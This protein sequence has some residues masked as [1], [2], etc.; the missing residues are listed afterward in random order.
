MTEANEADQS[1]FEII[2]DSLFTSAFAIVAIGLCTLPVTFS[3]NYLFD[4]VAHIQY[5]T[6][7]TV[8]TWGLYVAQLTI[9]ADRDTPNYRSELRQRLNRWANIVYH[10]VVIA[11]ATIGGA[12]LLS[13]PY[14]SDVGVL[15]AMLV[16]TLH[17]ELFVRRNVIRSPVVYLLSWF[18][19]RLARILEQVPDIRI[20]EPELGAV[21]NL[22]GW[23]QRYQSR[24]M[25]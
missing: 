9:N 8:V 13:V 6:G 25:S 24:R 4:S 11:I 2:V 5:V 1:L 19:T 21:P 15:F 12:L 17:H 16:P 14:V 18:F 22:D 7:L 23:V 20:T 10:N 3:V